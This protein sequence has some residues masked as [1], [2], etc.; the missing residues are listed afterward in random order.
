MHARICK[1]NA[2]IKQS[3]K[4]RKRGT[5]ARDSRKKALRCVMSVNQMFVLY[6]FDSFILTHKIIHSY[7]P[8]IS[9]LAAKFIARQAIQKGCVPSYEASKNFI[10]RIR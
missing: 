3:Q 1:L 2:K 4:P 6:S 9:L 7:L 5:V 8:I 10:D